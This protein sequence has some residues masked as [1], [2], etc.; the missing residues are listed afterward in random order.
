[1]AII[2]IAVIVVAGSAAATVH[3]RK[4]EKL[5]ETGQSQASSSPDS[6]LEGSSSPETT[7]EATQRPSAAVGAREGNEGDSDEPSRAEELQAQKIAIAEQQARNRAMDEQLQRAIAEG[8]NGTNEAAYA[9]KCKQQ[10]QSLLSKADSVYLTWRADWELARDSIASCYDTSSASVCDKQMTQMNVAWQA[11]LD[12]RFEP[13]Y[14]QLTSCASSDRQ[15]SDIS[16]VV[17]TGY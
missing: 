16:T 17:S 7:P 2:A 12:A 5:P 14:A 9:K 11:K 4:A 13:L 3:Y 1:M 15:F 8:R 10:K 6:A